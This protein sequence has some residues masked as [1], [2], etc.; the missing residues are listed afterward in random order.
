MSGADVFAGTNKREGGLLLIQ[1]L[2]L[3]HDTYILD[4]KLQHLCKVA[5]MPCTL[6]A[7]FIWPLGEVPAEC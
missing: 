3:L 1:A 6:Y 4:V 2:Q 5:T 7:V